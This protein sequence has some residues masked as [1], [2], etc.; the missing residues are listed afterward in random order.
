MKRAISYAT[1][2]A[3]GCDATLLMEMEAWRSSHGDGGL[4]VDRFAEREE[5]ESAAGLEHL[6]NAPGVV[7]RRQRSKG[8][9][10]LNPVLRL[11]RRRI[12]R[13]RSRIG[14]QSTGS[15]NTAREQTS[16]PA[17]GVV[18]VASSEACHHRA[19]SL[20]ATRHIIAA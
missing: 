18:S 1:V 9:K 17:G 6:L 10:R 5:L 3:S 15:N 13:P 19:G 7:R 20:L 4:D 12:S 11:E 16:A 8:R 2:A 14:C